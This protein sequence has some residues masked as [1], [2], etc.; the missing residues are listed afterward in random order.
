M[1]KLT[2]KQKTAAEACFVACASALLKREDPAEYEH[3]RKAFMNEV[4]LLLR[5]LASEEEQVQK[6]PSSS[7][8]KSKTKRSTRSQ[9]KS[10]DDE[11]GQLKVRRKVVIKADP[12]KKNKKSQTA[13]I[14]RA[15][16]KGPMTDS[17][18]ARD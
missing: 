5:E 11:S 1:S 7:S 16:R 12:P 6:K 17:W 18:L 13:S 9:T 14:T 4:K 3:R 15:E 10:S 8:S 2:S